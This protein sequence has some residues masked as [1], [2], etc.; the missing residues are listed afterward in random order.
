MVTPLPPVKAV[1]N[2]QHRGRDGRSGHA[3]AKSGSKDAAKASRRASPGEEQAG[4]R[5]QGQ[6]WQ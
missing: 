2:E 4:Q 3:T 6:R 1:K 5:K